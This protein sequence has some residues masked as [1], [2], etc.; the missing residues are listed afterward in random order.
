MGNLSCTSKSKKHPSTHQNNTHNNE[1]FHQKK[2]KQPQKYTTTPA[3]T[4]QPSPEIKKLR[5]SSLSQF[6]LVS[7]ANLPTK[8]NSIS[9]IANQNS[10]QLIFELTQTFS[11]YSG[12]C[13]LLGSFSH[14]SRD[15]KIK[16]SK[17]MMYETQ[18]KNQLKRIGFSNEN[19]QFKYVN[20]EIQDSA[21]INKQM[22][23]ESAIH[24]EQ[25]LLNNLDVVQNI[26]Q[27]LIV[28]KEFEQNF[29][30][31]IYN[32]Q[33]LGDDLSFLQ[34]NYYKHLSLK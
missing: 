14:L 7:N 10:E 15:L 2:Q 4:H 32:I 5:S 34:E 29:P 13:M 28:N 1:N 27:F 17:F 23:D 33:D 21:K 24:L 12:V 8:E 19:S 25:I 3:T 22:L 6:K 20:K 26:I 11:K 31:L 16:I 9:S 18:V 30:I